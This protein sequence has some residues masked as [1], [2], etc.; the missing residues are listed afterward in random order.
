LNVRSRI[1]FS[2]LMVVPAIAIGEGPAYLHSVLQLDAAPQSTAPAPKANGLKSDSEQA[3]SEF[4]RNEAEVPTGPA[5][6]IDGHPDL[7]GY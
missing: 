6:R 3:V 2:V 5:P 4:S 7:S 1:V